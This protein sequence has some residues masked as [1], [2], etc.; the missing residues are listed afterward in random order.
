V[1]VVG[2][3]FPKLDLTARGQA[4]MRRQQTVVLALPGAAGTAAAAVAAAPAIPSLSPEVVAPPALPETVR[5]EETDRPA[6]SYDPALFEQL[7]AQRTT[8][9][10]EEAIPPYCVLN[11]RSLRELAIHLPTTPAA[12]LQIYGIGETKAK[13]Y[14]E[15]FLTLIRQHLAQ[16]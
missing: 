7:R 16:P 6:A 11:D 1:Q 12:L 5:L 14:G 3:E 13:K 8:M 4:V 9:A 2:D 10:R 15:A